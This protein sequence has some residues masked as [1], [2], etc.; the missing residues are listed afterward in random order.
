METEAS[1][2]WIP[3]PRLVGKGAPPQSPSVECLGVSASGTLLGLVLGSGVWWSL[4]SWVSDSE[5][6]GGS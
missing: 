3:L 4:P 6:Q 2:N 5:C 1:S